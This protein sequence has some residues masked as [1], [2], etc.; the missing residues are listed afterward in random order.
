MELTADRGYVALLQQ[1]SDTYTQGRMQAVQAVNTHITQTYWQVGRQIVEFEQGGKARAEYGKALISSLADDLS[2]RH[3]KGFSRTNLVYMRLLYQRY[4]ISQKPSDLL[5]WSHYVE[6]LKLDDDLERSFYEQQAI[7]EKWSV[8]ELKRQKDSA[9]FLRLAASKDKAGILQ[10]AA[11]GQLTLQ[12]ADLLHEPYVFE[13]LNLPARTRRT[14]PRA[15]ADTARS[16]CCR[17]MVAMTLV[18][19]CA[20]YTWSRGRF[21]INFGWLR[22]LAVFGVGFQYAR[23]SARRG[24]R[25]AE[26]FWTLTPITAGSL[27]AGT[28]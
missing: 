1:I 7:H 20:R 12:P 24:S 27:A 10:L 6:L 26:A 28:A 16:G 19:A 9:L 14:A 21:C 22:R 3:G 11:Q 13:F 5:S 8:P 23:A 17:R 25:Q 15:G 2:L 4:P 18:A